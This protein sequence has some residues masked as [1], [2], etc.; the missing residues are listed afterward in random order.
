M[1]GDIKLA[2][3]DDIG[4]THEHIDAAVVSERPRL[5]AVGER[6]P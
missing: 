5:F 4:Q 6:D 2:A 3:V 1:A